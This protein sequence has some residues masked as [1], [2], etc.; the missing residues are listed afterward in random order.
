MNKFLRIIRKTLV[1]SFVFLVLLGITGYIYLYKLPKGPEVTSPT[2]ILDGKDTF[3]MYAYEES[4]RK[5]IR[6][7]TYKPEGWQSGDKIVFV[8]HGGGRNADDYLDAWVTMAEENNLLILVPEFENKFAR[9][10]TNDYQEGNLFT[11]FGTKN[12]K[13]EWAYT[14]IENIFDHVKSVNDIANSTYDIFGHSAGGQFVHRMTMFMPDARIETAIAANAGF[15]SFPNDDIRYPY[16]IEN[17]VSET[18]LELAYQKK[19]IILLGELDNDPSLGTFRTTDMAMQQGAH[20]LERG[21]NF[22]EANAQLSRSSTWA[23]N[24]EIDTVKNVGHDYRNMSKAA[25]KWLD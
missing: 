6:V 18:D 15:Y 11:F 24:W 19:L 13:E 9:Y 16:G 25:I 20:R 14:V 2:L 12:P 5:S 10:T 3:V 1:Y 7:W 8:M 17:A 23:F 4:R 22:Y 21:S